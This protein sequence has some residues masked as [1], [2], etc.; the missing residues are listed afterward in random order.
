[1]SRVTPSR[2]TLAAFHLDVA[3][4][5]TRARHLQNLTAFDV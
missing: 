5:T 2:L 3:D 1:M 4:P